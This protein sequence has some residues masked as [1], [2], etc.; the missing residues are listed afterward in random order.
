MSDTYKPLTVHFHRPFCM[1]L[2][3]TGQ[4]Q[5]TAPTVRPSADS[6]GWCP[7][8]GRTNTNSCAHSQ[9]PGPLL[10][11]ARW[12]AA[13]LWLPRPGHSDRWISA[14]HTGWTRSPLPGT[15]D[16]WEVGPRGCW[17][18]PSTSDLFVS[19]TQTSNPLACGV[20]PVKG[21]EIKT[22][23]VHNGITF[24]PQASD[25][26]F[27]ES[28][29]SSASV[30]TCYVFLSSESPNMHAPTTI[31]LGE[32]YKS[33]S[34]TCQPNYTNRPVPPPHVTAITTAPSSCWR[35]TI[36]H[37]SL[38]TKLSNQCAHLFIL[39][40]TPYGNY[41]NL[42]DLQNNNN[43]FVLGYLEN[44]AQ[45]NHHKKSVSTQQIQI[46]YILCIMCL[47]SIG[48]CL[49]LTTTARW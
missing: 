13:A 12:E 32:A 41:I 5:C 27:S 7:R 19:H 10:P 17:R 34:H 40:T 44:G 49:R 14:Q 15:Q 9:S 24:P 6:P 21:T 31:R 33:S 45:H 36:S 16:T 8:P 4:S 18:G 2:I 42:L 47:L 28:V 35:E 39:F 11:V 26:N 46:V 22:Q 1:K 29:S 37:W 25:L 43:A 48:H 38:V 20:D 3:R 23:E 30:F